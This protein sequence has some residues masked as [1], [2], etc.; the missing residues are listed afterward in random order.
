M[1]HLLFLL[2]LL[3][4]FVYGQTTAIYT[5]QGSSMSSPLETQIVTTEGVVTADFQSLND[6]FF[7]QDTAGDGNVL[8]SDGIF[9]YAP[10]GL[11]V[12]VGDY[13]SV[14]GEVQEF[15]GLTEIGNVSNITILGVLGTSFPPTDI[16]LPIGA[17]DDMERYEGM[18]VRYPQ[19]LYVTDQY[20]LGQYGEFSLATNQ[21]EIPTNVVDPN[22][23]PANGTTTSGNT[24]VASVWALE[25]QNELSTI[26]VDDIVSGSWPNPVPFIDPATKTLR[27]G[28][29][30][31]NIEGPITYSFGKYRLLPSSTLNLNHQPRPVVPDVGGN[32]KI[33]S[34]NVLNFFT[35]IDNGSNGARGADSQS[36]YIRQRDKIVAAL[37]SMRADIFA[38]IEIENNGT[39]AIDSLVAALNTSIGSNDYALVTESNYIDPYEI[40]NVFIYNVNTVLPV[41]STMTSTDTLFYPAPIAHQFELMATGERFNLFANHFRFKGCSG[42]TGLDQDQNDGQACFNETRRQQSLELLNFITYVEGL[43]GNGHHLVVGDFN[44]YEQED[45]IDI[46]VGAGLHKLIDSSWSFAFQ[47]QFGMLD[48]VFAS[49]SLFSKV[50]GAEVWHIN[51]TEPRTIDYNEENITDD[52]YEVNPYRS[53][54]H[55]PVL[56]GLN[57]VA[58][59]VSIQELST[60]AKAY[61]NPVRDELIIDLAHTYSNTSLEIFDYTGR[62]LDQY[63]F[64]N[65]ELLQ[66]NLASYPSGPYLV[67]LIADGEFS[68]IRVVKE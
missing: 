28:T 42:A 16:V 19:N 39:T 25:G 8:T 66:V 3:P 54:D 52:L 41:D 44:A 30:I 45:P 29:T 58:S 51:S 23:N 6:G 31:Q 62:K 10:G 17:V 50:T 63:S 48:H 9:I 20:N 47:G 37:D 5:I 68:T 65:Q 27:C 32:V 15:F 35:T 2:A 36:E 14:T 22:D 11:N 40:K 61:P 1:K 7:L 13:V 21:L 24:N 55:D 59:N 34:F 56:V 64:N 57:L 60:S 53:S 43:T 38:L 33:A 12:D 67:R 18:L 46:L 4:A 26:V 49:D